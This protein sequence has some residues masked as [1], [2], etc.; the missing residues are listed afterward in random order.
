MSGHIVRK[1]DFIN[2]TGHDPY[3]HGG[4]VTIV[5]ELDSNRRRM[6]LGFSFCSP[7]DPFVKR[8]GVENAIRRL[9]ECPIEV[10]VLY[11]ADLMAHEILKALC[12]R[13]WGTL[14]QVTTLEIHTEAWKRAVPSWAKKWW[15]RIFVK[16]PMAPFEEVG[17]AL[18]AWGDELTFRAFKRA[19][20]GVA[21]DMADLTRATIT[22]KEHV[23]GMMSKLTGACVCPG[24]SNDEPAAPKP[25]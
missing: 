23:V 22:L 24:M 18:A 5:L 15:R 25:H 16:E 3:R 1:T 17:E 19:R 14:E 2:W 6:K 12:T 13:D 8:T 9:Q 10:P 21:K 4:V 7:D 11:A 20:M